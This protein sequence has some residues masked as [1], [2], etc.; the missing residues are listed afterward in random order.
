MKT[1]IIETAIVKPE[2]K[3]YPSGTFFVSPKSDFKVKDV[4]VFN[5][6]K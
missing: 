4:K 6:K 3:L 2:D 1:A 5:K